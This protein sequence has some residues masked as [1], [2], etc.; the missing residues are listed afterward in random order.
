MEEDTLEAAIPEE[1]GIPRAVATQEGD[2]P[3]EAAVEVRTDETARAA[4]GIPRATKD[5]HN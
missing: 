1:V 4:D 2:G 3:A 5:W